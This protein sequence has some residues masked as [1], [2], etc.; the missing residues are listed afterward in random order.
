MSLLKLLNLFYTFLYNTNAHIR[1]IKEKYFYLL[2]LFYK[3]SEGVITRYMMIGECVCL[4]VCSS[5]RA[6]LVSLYDIRPAASVR[7]RP[8]HSGQ[9]S[10]RLSHPKPR[11]AELGR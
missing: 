3:F 11:T 2:T 9:H 6:V 8:G 5:V 4:S 10:H 1:E 7:L